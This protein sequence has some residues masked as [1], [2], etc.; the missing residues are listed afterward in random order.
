MVMGQSNIFPLAG[1]Y[2]ILA[3]MG[4]VAS[5]AK[6]YHGFTNRF[7][8]SSKYDVTTLG[9]HKRFLGPFLIY[10]PVDAA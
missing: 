2:H 8:S 10:T 7:V 3:A 1:E 6:S 9:T 5:D 4:P